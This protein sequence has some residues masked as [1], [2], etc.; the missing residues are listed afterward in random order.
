MCRL[1]APSLDHTIRPCVEKYLLQDP[2]VHWILL[3]L[4]THEALLRPEL[5]V[6]VELVVSVCD[7]VNRECLCS[8]SPANDAEVATL[9]G[10]GRTHAAIRAKNKKK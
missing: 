1:H 7:V 4:N 8:N 5:V 9:V 3:T 10:W 2:R 6:L